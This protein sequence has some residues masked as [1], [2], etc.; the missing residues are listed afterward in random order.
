MVQ[1]QRISDGAVFDVLGVKNVGDL[2]IGE[3][4]T[5]RRV[6][7]PANSTGFDVLSEYVQ[8][9]FTAYPP[10]ERPV[11]GGA[12]SRLD[13]HGGEHVFDVMHVVEHGGGMWLQSRDAGRKPVWM[14][15]SYVMEFFTAYPP[16]EKPD[17]VDRLAEETD[18]WEPLVAYRKAFCPADDKELEPGYRVVEAYA[19]AL[20]DA[21]FCGT[22]NR[23]FAADTLIEIKLWKD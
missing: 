2:P 16:Q 13:I 11:V 10:Q 9:C 12:L 23:H 8:K 21:L 15:R 7:G 4:I 5:L 3:G 14:E 6:D 20:V 22:C 17:R 1:L 18:G 19:G